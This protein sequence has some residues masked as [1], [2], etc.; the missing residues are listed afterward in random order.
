MPSRA[1][2]TVLEAVGG[3]PLIRVQRMNRGP[4]ELWVKWEASNPG[5]SIKDRIA[6]PLVT[7]LEQTGQLAPGG[8]VVEA[9]AGNTG[10]A[11]AMACAVR[12]YRSLFVVP[13]KMSQ[14]KVRVLEAYGAMVVRTVSNVSHDHPDF[15][16]VMARRL[17]NEIP[18]AVYAGQFEAPANP[19]AHEASTGPE[20]WA[21]TGGR[22]THLVA[23]AGTGGTLSGTGRFLKRQNPRIR[24][25]A[26][27][28]VGSHL[29]GGPSGSYQVEGIGGEVP[30]KTFDTAVV[31]AYEV[32]TDAES[33]ATARAAARLEGLLGGG[34]SG[35]A[36]A[37][38]LRVQEQEGSQA[39]IVAIFPDTGRNYLSGFYDADWLREACPEALAMEAKRWPVP[40]AG[41]RDDFRA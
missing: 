1:A 34:S 35:T 36:L 41:K 38:A 10:V 30:P 37:A 29:S 13:D 9:T 26:A 21:A 18:G 4:G 23:G 24:I 17:A 27:D 12:G 7:A 2:D 6:G 14:E 20:I 11:L 8:L 25:V 15:Y 28:P 22:V 31:D 16:Q 19:L 33:F 32:V 39:V 5:G 40:N 3:T